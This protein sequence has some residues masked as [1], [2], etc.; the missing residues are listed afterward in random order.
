M[1]CSSHNCPDCGARLIHQV[2]RGQNESSSAYGQHIH[3]DHPVDFHWADIDGVVYKLDTGIMRIIE[4][5]PV[6]GALR[7]SQRAILPLLA[8][9]IDILVDQDVLHPDSGVFVVN[10]DPPF[11]TALVRRY[12]RSPDDGKYRP[13]SIRDAVRLNGIDLADFE[14]GKPIAR[15]ELVGLGNVA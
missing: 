15:H 7:D 4:H 6:G 13:G 5:K 10:S 11:D 2:S 1:A 3:D 12:R 9:C 8:G 14:T